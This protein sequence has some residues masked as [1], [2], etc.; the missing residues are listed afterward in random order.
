VVRGG[1]EFEQSTMVTPKVKEMISR[2]AELAPAHTPAGWEGIEAV[3][4]ILGA[5][6]QVAVFDTA[7]QPNYRVDQLD[8][9]LNQASG[10][11]GISGISSDLR[12]ISAAMAD[13]ARMLEA[14]S[15]LKGTNL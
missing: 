8:R 15:F 2:L 10:L 6:P 14:D 3:E 12:E 1:L 9:I 11:E 13:C 4:H 7:F 5:V